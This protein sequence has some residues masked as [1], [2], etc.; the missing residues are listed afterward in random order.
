G[1]SES[2]LSSACALFGSARS[3]YEDSVGAATTAPLR[4]AATKMDRCV[5]IP[6]LAMPS[7][8]DSTPNVIP[9]LLAIE[10][11]L[12]GRSIRAVPRLS[13]GRTSCSHSQYAPARCHEL[14]L[15][16][17]STGLIHTHTVDALSLGD[18][19]NNITLAR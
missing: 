6:R 5:M 14:I 9:P 1:L 13:Q 16:H 7:S 11:D 2:R 12:S 10:V 3:P 19:G 18:A 8:F 15:L 4:S 17:A